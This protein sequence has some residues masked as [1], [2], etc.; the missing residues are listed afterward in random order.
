MKLTIFYWG[1]CDLDQIILNGDKVIN[2]VISI[3]SEADAYY[4]NKF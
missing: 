2:N 4:K 3:T 1:I